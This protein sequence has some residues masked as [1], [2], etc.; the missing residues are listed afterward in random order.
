MRTIQ[1]FSIDFKFVDNRATDIDTSAKNSDNA[2]HNCDYDVIG[3]DNLCY[4]FENGDYKV[5]DGR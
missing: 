1:T 2:Y 4:Y 3:I 5:E